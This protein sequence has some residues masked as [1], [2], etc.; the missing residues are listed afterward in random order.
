MLNFF[1]SIYHVNFSTSR[2]QSNLA[3]VFEL[4]HVLLVLEV[5][6]SLQSKKGI[7]PTRYNSVTKT[8]SAIERKHTAPSQK[9]L[10]IQ[11]LPSSMDIANTFWNATPS[12]IPPSPSSVVTRPYT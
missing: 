5:S 1:V 11:P 2:T 10:A 7:W 3:V 6:E 4:G 8:A 9:G 12:T